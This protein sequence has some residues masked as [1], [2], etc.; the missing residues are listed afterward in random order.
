MSSYHCWKL[1]LKNVREKQLKQN[2]IK[3]QGHQQLS[4]K[5]D[6]N[7]LFPYCRFPLMRLSDFSLV[8]NIIDHEVLPRSLTLSTNKKSD[9]LKRKPLE[10]G[11]RQGCISQLSL[12]KI[13]FFWRHLLVSLVIT[14]IFSLLRLV[15][16]DE[17]G[18]MWNT[19]TPIFP[20]VFNIS[21]LL[22]TSNV[23][24]KSNSPWH[25]LKCSILLNESFKEKFCH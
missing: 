9:S 2:C 10:Y 6:E 18:L 3:W 17:G 22:E 20:N 1:Q 11:A 19:S 12:I 21:S 15:K 8:G 16:S 23:L 24:L 5:S 14:I 13:R 4:P 25:T 7:N